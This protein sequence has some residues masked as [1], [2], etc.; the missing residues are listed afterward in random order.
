MSV[1]RGVFTFTH[2]G[3][4]SCARKQVNRKLS[5][6]TAFSL[7]RSKTA[8]EFLYQLREMKWLSLC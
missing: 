1:I 6:I 3:F 7:S 8:R 5:E 2:A 4:V